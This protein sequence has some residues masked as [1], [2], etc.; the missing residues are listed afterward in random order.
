LLVGRRREEII[1]RVA[2]GERQKAYEYFSL[3]QAL[4]PDLGP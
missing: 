1:E 4:P 2:G 3:K